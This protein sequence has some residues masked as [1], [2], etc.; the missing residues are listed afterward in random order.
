MH[1]SCVWIPLEARMS[2]CVVEAFRWADH[3]SN[4]SYR[5]CIWNWGRNGNRSQGPIKSYRA[6]SNNDNDNNNNNNF[7]SVNFTFRYLFLSATQIK[8]SLADELVFTGL[9]ILQHVA[10]IDLS[11]FWEIRYVRPRICCEVY[12]AKHSRDV[13]MSWWTLK[14]GFECCNL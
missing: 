10:L 6:I 5:A 12:V 2:V 7:S 11:S 4:G 9:W 14:E 3:P 1:V 8:I 13:R